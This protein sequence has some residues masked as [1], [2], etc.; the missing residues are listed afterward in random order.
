MK[1][2]PVQPLAEQAINDALVSLPH[3]IRADDALQR[4]MTFPTFLEAV[5]AIVTVA[6][7]A[8]AHEHHP[9]IELRWRMVRFTLTTHDADGV[10]DRDVA[11]A[12]AID[13]ALEH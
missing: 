10:T 5:D 9:D 8:E 7:L 2:A 6:A 3:W 11:L 4:E 1:N 12:H 13:A